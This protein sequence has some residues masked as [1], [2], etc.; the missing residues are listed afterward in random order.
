MP[1]AEQYVSLSQEIYQKAVDLIGEEIMGQATSEEWETGTMGKVRN[2]YNINA[3]DSK[4][5]AIDDVYDVTNANNIDQIVSRQEAAEYSSRQ[6]GRAFNGGT[7]SENLTWHIELMSKQYAAKHVGE[8]MLDMSK[9]HPDIVKV[10]KRNTPDYSKQNG[11]LVV[12]TV[13]NKGQLEKEVVK[14]S[15]ANEEANRA[16]FGE[17]IARFTQSDNLV[18]RTIPALVSSLTRLSSAGLT[19]TFGFSVINAYKGYNEK[20]NQLMAFTETS[21][22]VK[23]M[24]PQGQK[25]FQSNGALDTYAKATKLQAFLTKNKV[26]ETLMSPLKMFAREKAALLFSQRLVD[27]GS[28][29]EKVATILSGLVP[30]K[31]NAVQ[32]ELDKLELMYKSGGISSRVEDLI[33]TS[34]DLK[35]RFAAGKKFTRLVDGAKAILDTASTM[36]MSQELV[37]SLMMYDLLTGTFGMDQQKAIEANLHFM[38]FNKRGAS[39]LMGYIRNYTMFGNAIAQGAKAFQHA[40]LEQTNNPDDNFLGI[41]PGYKWSPKGT[42][43]MV[44]NVAIAVSLNLLARAIADYACDDNGK[45]LGNPISGMNPYQLLREVPIVVGCSES[46]YGAIRFPVEYG[47]GNVENALGVSAVQVMTGAWSVSQAKGFIIDSLSD[48]AVPV[49]IPVAHG[50]TPFQ[51]AALLLFPLVPEPFKDPTLAA[52]GLDNFGNRLNSQLASFKDY[53]PDTGKKSTDP[54][55]GRISNALYD[56]DLMGIRA[57]LTPEETKVLV[58]GWTKGVFQKVLT[59]VVEDEPKQSIWEAMLG[60]SYFYRKERG[61]DKIAYAMSQTYMNDRYSDLTA[62][63]IKAKGKDNTDPTPTWLKKNGYEL[64]DKEMKLLKSITKYRHALSNTK[65]SQEKRFNDNVTF[66]KSIREIEGIE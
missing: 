41:L 9:T 48:N 33:N 21:P 27:N 50:S 49:S 13:N 5:N 57:N 52:M 20:L 22:F 60:V 47:A 7:A 17:N 40:Y 32:A 25:W 31:R 36:T 8:V 51:K 29:A 23:A 43:R 30:A 10:Y 55:W 2:V 11:I 45:Q 15:F 63:A 66:I 65:A 12:R 62:I 18:L 61:W 46:G 4:G 58:T 34:T 14:V 28:Y 19:T 3:K 59:A 35:I 42:A 38:N 24:S 1:I 44:N 6:N 39:K 54:A 56:A 64:D 37:S 26:Q 53:K 16:L